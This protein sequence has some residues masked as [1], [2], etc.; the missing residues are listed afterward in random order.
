MKVNDIIVDEGFW[1]SIKAGATALKDKASSAVSATAN[2]VKSA[3]GAASYGSSPTTHANMGNKIVNNV[4]ASTIK[5]WE[6]NKLP[7]LSDAVKADPAAYKKYLDR[8]LNQY[9]REDYSSDLE[10]QTTDSKAVREYI[11]QATYARNNGDV[12]QP[13]QEQPGQEQPTQE[14]PTAPTPQS[15]LP[16]TQQPQRPPQPQLPSQ[17][18]LTAPAATP[19]SKYAATNADAEDI[20]VKTPGQK[21]AAPQPVV[22]PASM[23]D[24]FTPAYEQAVKR[25][26]QA[27]LKLI[28]A[29]RQ[30]KAQGTQSESIRLRGN[31]LLESMITEGGNVFDDVSPIKKEFVPGLIKNIQSLMPP[32]INIVPHIGSAGFKI[33]SG[34]MDV[35]VDAGKIANFFKAP[36]DKIAKV[37]FKQYVNDKGFQA[38]LTGRNVHVRMPVPDGTFV[39]V[40]V[41]VIPDAERVAP[42]HQHGPSGQYEDPDFKGGHLFIMYSSLAKA[43]GLKFSPF[44]GKLVDR[45]TN[46]VVADNKDAAAKILLNPAATGADMASVKSIMRALAN[47]PRKEEKLAQ[48]R[49]DAT[50]GLINLPE[51]VQPG[52]AQWFRN[53]QNLL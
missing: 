16:A 39:Q 23:K 32:G 24:E 6:V 21:P 26:D 33:Q 53:L 34:D 3:K 11:K 9:Y 1:D 31:K 28:A 7:T 40:D 37:R 13:K 18:R 12:V 17:P 41:M 44:E 27:T 50:K 48:A 10:L 43:L 35:F 8:F 22:D 29:A 46:K 2:A 14:Q 52:S 30:Q 51:S 25:G 47:D 5:R 45:A 36:D 42:F 15:N 20:E 4:T 38:A 49:A 19:A